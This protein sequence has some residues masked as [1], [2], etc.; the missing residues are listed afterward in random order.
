MDRRK[1]IGDLGS[2][3]LAVCAVCL[4]ACTKADV[5]PS[6]NSGGG[7]VNFT[8]NLNSQLPNVGDALVQ[9]GVIVARV[10]AG[11]AVSSF[12]AV[13]VACTHQGTP[14]NYSSSGNKFICPLHHSQ[15]NTNGTLISGP[16]NGGTATALK[17]YN[18]A[19]N[20]ST[21]TITG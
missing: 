10:A 20:G 21:M 15:F 7:G 3:V 14:I 2:P 13:Q 8:V 12:A 18:I 16:D 19:I 5:S 4:G 1:F 6:N 17:A 9:S 11:N